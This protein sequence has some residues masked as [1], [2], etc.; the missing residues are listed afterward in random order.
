MHQSLNVLLDEYCDSLLRTRQLKTKARNRGPDGKDDVSQLTGMENSL[1]WTIEYM[2]TGYMPQYSEGP[3]RKQVPTDPQTVLSRYSNEAIK[4][5]WSNEK[6]EAAISILDGLN[7]KEKEACILVWIEGK[8]YREAGKI[9]KIPHTT[10]WD[11]CKRALEKL[12]SIKGEQ[13]RVKEV[14]DHGR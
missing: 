14:N 1:S 8:S 4:L 5:R 9:M 2:V 6:R 13:Y 12:E 3:Y 7:D 10:V 11:C